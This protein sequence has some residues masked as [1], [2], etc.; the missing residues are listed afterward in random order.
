MIYTVTFNPS[1]DYIVS[2]KSFDMGM[3]NRTTQEQMLPGGKG[4]NVSTVLTNLG[5]ENTALGFVAGFTGDEIIRRLEE[6]KLRND[7]IRIDNGFSRI[8]VKLKDYDGT[9][10]NGMGPVIDEASQKKLMDQLQT[11]KEGDTLVLA[12]SIPESMPSTIYHDIMEQLQGKGIR[13][14]VDATQK[15]LMNVLPF[16]PFL[17]KPNNHE[18]GEIFGVELKTRESVVP[19]A[20]KL[21]EQ[22][23]VNVLVSMAGEGAVLLD[24]NGEVHMHEAAKGKLVNAVGAG[25]SMVAGFIAGYEEKKDYEHAFR[26][27]ISAGSASAFSELLAT[28]EEV[29][30]VYDGLG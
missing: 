26:M 24:E 17:I 9:E 5:H 30:K 1:I 3:T 18:L 28:K 20:R 23:A 27:G 10:I 4:I 7:F 13:F 6:M 14:V 29:M 22:G 12:G 25:D 15:L 16:H 2:M 8:N 21:Q 19:Y 11:M